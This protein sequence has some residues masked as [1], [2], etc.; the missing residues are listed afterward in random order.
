MARRP[1]SVRGVGFERADACPLRGGCMSTE[2]RVGVIFALYV[3]YQT[4]GH[5]PREPIRVSPSAW[6]ELAALRADL[7]GLLREASALQWHRDAMGH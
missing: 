3:T 1:R 4:Q 6:H 7:M 2:W 5:E